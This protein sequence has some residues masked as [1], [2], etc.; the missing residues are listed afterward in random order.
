MCVCSPA[1]AWRLLQDWSNGCFVLAAKLLGWLGPA[2]ITSASGLLKWKGHTLSLGSLA[3][4]RLGR[5][6]GARKMEKKSHYGSCSPI[7]PLSRQPGCKALQELGLPLRP[8]EDDHGAQRLHPGPQPC[9]RL[10]ST[11]SA[12]ACMAASETVSG[13]PSLQKRTAGFLQA[14]MATSPPL[15]GLEEDG[16][17]PGGALCR[18]T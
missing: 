14:H 10:V 2:A 15:A 9:Q 12:L 13:C 11:V 18:L 6:T 4:W 5:Q 1:S 7:S 3:A 16:A 17:L 8:Q